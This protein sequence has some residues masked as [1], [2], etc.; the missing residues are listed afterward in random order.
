MKNKKTTET[1]ELVYISGSDFDGPVDGT[2][3]NLETEKIIKNHKN[4]KIVCRRIDEKTAV[5]CGYDVKD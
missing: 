5:F 2:D 3:W 4:E 1:Q